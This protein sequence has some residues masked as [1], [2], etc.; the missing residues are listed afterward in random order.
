MTAL[1]RLSRTQDEWIALRCQAG[2][3]NAFEDLVA[4]MERPLLYYAT[5]LTGNTETAL[6]V[7]QDVWMVVFRGI[8]RLKDPGSL[9][10]WLY[11]IT[12]GLAVCCYP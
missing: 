3:Q 5:K 10:P 6:D 8:K 7:L 12:H 1:D 9:R 2:E 4:S 11:R